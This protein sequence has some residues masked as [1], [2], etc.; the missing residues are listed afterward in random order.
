MQLIITWLPRALG[1]ILTVLVVLF[2]VDSVSAGVGWL[3]PLVAAAPGLIILIAT[4]IAWRGPFLGGVIFLGLG[5]SYAYQAY[6]QGTLTS[7]W[8][9]LIMLTVI[10]VLAGILF[11]L[12]KPNQKFLAPPPSKP[13]QPSQPSTPS[14]PT[15]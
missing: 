14:Q 4:A 5:L 11:L 6:S 8:A 3:V 7:N 9:G 1:I 10:P 2:A 13:S 15:K 12:Q